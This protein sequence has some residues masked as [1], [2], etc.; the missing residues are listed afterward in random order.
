MAHGRHRSISRFRAK[1]IEKRQKEHRKG[2][3][4]IKHKRLHNSNATH[5]QDSSISDDT[6]KYFIYGAIVIGAYYLYTQK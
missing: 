2:T 1:Q 3:K 6:Q 5:T 4:S